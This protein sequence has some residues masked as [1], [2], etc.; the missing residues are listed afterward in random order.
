MDPNPYG[1]FW[2]RT[3]S[4]RHGL[5][6]WLAR[7]WR[8]AIGWLRWQLWGRRSAARAVRAFDI[9]LEQINEK[10]ERHGE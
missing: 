5:P 10:G 1:I 8:R 9:Y 7:W 6:L 4:T 3:E 2:M